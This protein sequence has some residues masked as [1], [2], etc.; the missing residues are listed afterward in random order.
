[1]LLVCLLLLERSSPAV[2]IDY[3]ADCVNAE[4]FLVSLAD[5][6]VVQSCTLIW[7]VGACQL[8]FEVVLLLLLNMAWLLLLEGKGYFAGHCWFSDE[9]IQGGIQTRKKCF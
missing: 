6:F 1:M 9:L 5:F 2:F 7:E 8:V 3:L 4:S